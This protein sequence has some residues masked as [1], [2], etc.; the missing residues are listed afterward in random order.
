MSREITFKV[1][2]VDNGFILDLDGD[3]GSKRLVCN[4]IQEVIKEIQGYWDEHSEALD[5]A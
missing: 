4:D 3:I 1:E 2:E 5:K